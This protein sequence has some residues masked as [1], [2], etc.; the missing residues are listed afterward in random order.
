MGA[1]LSKV[2][3]L[4]DNDDICNDVFYHV[5]LY[6]LYMSIVTLPGPM[7]IKRI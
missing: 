7:Q 2:S 3:L 1:T 5:R 4:Q 6:K